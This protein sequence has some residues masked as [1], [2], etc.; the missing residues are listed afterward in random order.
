MKPQGVLVWGLGLVVCAGVFSHTSRAAELSAPPERGPAAAPRPGP[1]VRMV[2]HNDGSRT[3]TARDETT[4]EM[5]IT[6]YDPEGNLKLR[7]N[8]QLDR[9]GKPGTFQ[10]FDGSGRP[11][12]RGEFI[13][14]G[15]DRVVE[16]KW[17][18]LPSERPIR[19][20]AQNYDAKGRRLPP[21]SMHEATLPPEVV[22]WL[23]PDKEVASETSKN[24]EGSRFS[25]FGKKDKKKEAAPA[26]G[27]SPPPAATG[28][29]SGLRNIF[30]KPKK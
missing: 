7:R 26:T 18:E 2:R 11:L 14:D 24:Q 23:E 1:F 25:L 29:K 8:Y 16:E 9:Y 30:G 3:V 15:M 13:Y 10:F 19:T 21:Q 12:V 28:E 6:T 5:V 27:S 20:L 22:R 17:F 4:K